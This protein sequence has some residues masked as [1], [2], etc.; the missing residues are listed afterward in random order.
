[1]SLFFLEL[2]QT[3]IPTPQNVTPPPFPPNKKKNP[4]TLRQ[5]TSPHPKFF[6]LFSFS[7]I[8]NKQ[9][10]PLKKTEMTI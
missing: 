4:S 9:N 10:S 5:K 7:N 2:Q 3:N 6:T 8:N 1:M